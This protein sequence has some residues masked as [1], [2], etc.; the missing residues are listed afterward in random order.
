MSLAIDRSD[1]NN[2]HHLALLAE[3]TKKLMK[4]DST[5]FMP[6]LSQRHPQAIAFSA[7]LIHK[8][9]GNKLKPFLDGAEHLTEDAVSVFPAADSLEQY[10][11]E[12]MT[13]VCGEDTSGPYFKKLIPYEVRCFTLKSKTHG[14]SHLINRFKFSDNHVGYN[15]SQ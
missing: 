14:L 10:L 11:L 9:Y 2:E 4:K 6:I 5:I 13:S 1:R 8:L 7:S 15:I 3:E 12:L